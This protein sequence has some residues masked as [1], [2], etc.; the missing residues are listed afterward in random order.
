M[1]RRISALGRSGSRAAD[2]RS[3]SSGHTAGS[4]LGAYGCAAAAALLLGCSADDRAAQAAI[5]SDLA[6]SQAE[7]RVVVAIVDSSIN[8]YHAYY[9]AGS[10]IYPDVAPSSVTPSV[11]SELGV[12]P[13]DRVR[14]TRSGDIDAD[15]QA[16]ADFWDRVERGR[17][18]WFEG[19]NIV[20]VSFCEES[21]R[22]LQPQVEKNPHGTGTSAAMLKANPE[23]VLL[24]VEACADPDPVELKYVLEHPAVDIFSYS[25]NYGLPL[26]VAGAYSGVVERGKLMFQAAGNY[27]VP[28]TYQGGAG[29]WW[30][31][32]VS[33]IDEQAGGQVATS[34]WLPDFV[35]EFTDTLPFCSDCEEEM[36]TIAGTSLSTP[37]A[38]GL[39]SRLLLEL[40]RWLGHRG[41]IRLDDEQTAAMVVTKD[42][43]ISNWDIRRA[44]EEAAYVDYGTDTYNPSA[45]DVEPILSD[46]FLIEQ[47][48]IDV[49]PVN[50][51]APWLQLAWGDLS[52]D[53]EKGV[54]SEAMGFF[55]FGAPTRV[56]P[57][58]YCSFMADEM[59]A[60]QE[61]SDIRGQATGETV[62]EPNPYIFCD[63]N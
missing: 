9:Y 36:L 15:I 57:E 48:L 43:R 12:A 5:V 51:V 42:R 27:V 10:P 19:S 6:G 52:T 41:G 29:S 26:T 54:V 11:L 33:G 21:L 35:A 56:K 62:P 14:L 7:A 60:R 22:P 32:A 46:P 63:A 34:A 2:R 59:R 4:R 47:A 16:D 49:I 61:Y 44:L 53:P 25:Y 17:P 40:R 55:G 8:P 50:P 28:P 24:F 45:P 3:N 31:I 38:A 37:Q 39:T 20:A 23:A 18:Y 58:G 1:L 30:T 13:E